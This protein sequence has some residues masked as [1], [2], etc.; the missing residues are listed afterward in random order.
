MNERTR[1]TTLRLRT[2]ATAPTVGAN[3]PRSFVGTGQRAG[4]EI[5]MGGEPRRAPLQTY[6]PNRADPTSRAILD[7]LASLGLAEPE[8]RD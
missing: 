5:R 1:A 3:P 4:L 7:E 6:V 8:E 2:P